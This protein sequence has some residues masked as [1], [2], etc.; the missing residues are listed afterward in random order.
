[1]ELF[2]TNL[3]LNLECKLLLTQNTAYAINKI[4]LFWKIS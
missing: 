3:S 2:N 4:I 1:M